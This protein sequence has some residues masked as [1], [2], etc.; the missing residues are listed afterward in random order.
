RGP[1]IELR[2]EPHDLD[3]T[4]DGRKAWVTLN[5]TDELALVDLDTASVV[6]YVPTG[7]RP[8]DIR[9]AP[10]G[11]IWITD[12]DGPL[13]VMTADGELVESIPLGVE[14]HHLAFIPDGSE[15]WV[16]DHATREAY[17]V[18]VASRQVVAA[19]PLPGAPHHVAITADGALAAIADHTNGSLLVFDVVR[20][21]HLATIPVGPGPHGV[22]ALPPPG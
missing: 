19:L 7:K 9:V 4:P 11:A 2:A 10:D 6:R 15:L 8:H 22:W 1:R 20:R 16:V 13:H 5:G 17:V 12:W 18:D 14:A 3:L 21:Q